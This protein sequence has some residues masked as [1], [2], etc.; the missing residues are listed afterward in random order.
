MPPCSAGSLR[1]VV[2]GWTVLAAFGVDLADL[3]IDRI[4]DLSGAHGEPFLLGMALPHAGV[5]LLKNLIAHG[6]LFFG[7]RIDAVVDVEE[8]GNTTLKKRQSHRTEV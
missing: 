3:A 8:N 5:G 7:R 4:G 6:S 1:R 2:R